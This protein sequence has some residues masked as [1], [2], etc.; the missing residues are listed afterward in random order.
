MSVSLALELLA[1][2]QPMHYQKMAGRLLSS[3]QS[4]MLECGQVM[5]MEPNSLSVVRE[6][7]RQAGNTKINLGW[8]FI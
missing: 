6:L 5:P 1:P 7:P 3:I 4:Q 2:L 8:L